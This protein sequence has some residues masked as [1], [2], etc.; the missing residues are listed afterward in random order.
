V[1]LNG[2][3]DEIAIGA[4]VEHLSMERARHERNGEYA[5]FEAHGHA[6]LDDGAQDAFFLRISSVARAHPVPRSPGS[7][8]SAAGRAGTDARSTEVL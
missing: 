6:V 5:A 2:V 4:I 1:L 7:A 3:G 8:P